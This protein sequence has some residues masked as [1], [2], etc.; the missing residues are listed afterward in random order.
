M[1]DFKKRLGEIYTEGNFTLRDILSIK[2]K[3]LVEYRFSG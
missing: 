1:G 3:E 2:E